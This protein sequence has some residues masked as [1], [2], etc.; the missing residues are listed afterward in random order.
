VGENIRGGVVTVVIEELL[1]INVGLVKSV[2]CGRG[3]SVPLAVSTNRSQVK[4]FLTGHVLRCDELTRK[5]LGCRLVALTCRH[6]IFPF[7][8]DEDQMITSQE[9]AETLGTQKR[10]TALPAPAP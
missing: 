8:L 1:Q 10:N 6:S 4:C 2:G 5:L 3:E 9:K 7:K